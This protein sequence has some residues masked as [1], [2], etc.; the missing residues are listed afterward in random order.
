M[1][2]SVLTGC[3]GIAAAEMVE[4]LP[5]LTFLPCDESGP[6]CASFHVDDGER[7]NDMHMAQRLDVRCSWS[8]KLNILGGE[9]FRMR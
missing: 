5:W 2:G 1:V 3:C 4:V 9:V 8:P 7:Y 6:I